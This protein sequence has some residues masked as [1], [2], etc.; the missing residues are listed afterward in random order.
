MKHRHTGI[1][2]MNCRVS[3]SIDNDRSN[4]TIRTVLLNSKD[5]FSYSYGTLFSFSTRDG[6]TS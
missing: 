2:S 4:S 1:R 6:M 3:E 5:S